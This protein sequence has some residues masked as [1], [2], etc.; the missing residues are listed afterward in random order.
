VNAYRAGSTSDLG[1]SSTTLWIVALAAAVIPIWNSAPTTFAAC[2]ATSPPISLP[3]IYLL[4]VLAL[5]TRSL[6]HPE[7]VFVHGF[8]EHLIDLSTDI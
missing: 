3:T 4:D 7:Q 5:A 8:V 6:L 2:R 1:P